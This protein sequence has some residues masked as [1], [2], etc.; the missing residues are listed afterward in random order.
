MDALRSRR[1]GGGS[2]P[3]RPSQARMRKRRNNSSHAIPAD[4][5]VGRAN[6][7]DRRKVRTLRSSFWDPVQEAP[8]RPATS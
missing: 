8:D 7:V 3:G 1:E 2:L 5:W 4:C 6:L